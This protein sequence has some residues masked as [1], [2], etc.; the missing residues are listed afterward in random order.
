MLGGFIPPLQPN[1]VGGKGDIFCLREN[2][3]L[4]YNFMRAA[5]PTSKLP[6]RSAALLSRHMGVKPFYQSR[7]G[8]SPLSVVAIIFSKCEQGKKLAAVFALA[9]TDPITG[10]FVQFT[11]LKGGLTISGY[12]YPW[13]GTSKDQQE[14]IQLALEEANAF[15]DRTTQVQV[16]QVSTIIYE[17]PE[18]QATYRNKLSTVGDVLTALFPTLI[19]FHP[20]FTIASIG[21]EHTP[22]DMLFTFERGSDARQLIKPHII[23]NELADHLSMLVSPIAA[24]SNMPAHN[25]VASASGKSPRASTP[26]NASVGS[27]IAEKFAAVKRHGTPP[28][29]LTLALARWRHHRT[30]GMICN[31]SR[32]TSP[33]VLGMLCLTPI[34][35]MRP[36]ESTRIGI[37]VDRLRVLNREEIV[38]VSPP[39]TWRSLT[40]SQSIP[41]TSRLIPI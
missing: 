5:S 22:P 14:V 36:Q 28:H 13:D 34:Y 16:P 33:A 38:R 35:V 7:K 19:G 1:A 39:M 40:Y 32:G 31:W 12:P 4:V 41:I 21:G 2:A 24:V 6:N 23:R 3:L 29:S 26:A 37:V 20:I 15:R 11:L 25:G 30:I 8:K 9:F 27:S 18:M 17:R 10:F